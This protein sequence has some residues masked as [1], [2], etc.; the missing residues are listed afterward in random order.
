MAQQAQRADNDEG[1]QFTKQQPVYRAKHGNVEI[2]VWPTK[3]Q[4]ERS[5]RRV[6]RRFA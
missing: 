5:T 1:A 6:R 2:P 4:T 3:A